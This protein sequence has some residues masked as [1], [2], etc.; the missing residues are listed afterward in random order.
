LALPRKKFLTKYPVEQTIR[1]VDSHNPDIGT[2]YQSKSKI[3]NLKW[4]KALFN[5]W[6]FCYLDQTAWR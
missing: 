3:Q 2:N 1:Q 4:Y 6:Y 5:C